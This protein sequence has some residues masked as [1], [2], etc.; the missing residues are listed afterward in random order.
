MPAFLVHGVPD[1]HHL[2]DGV[3]SRLSRE[4]VIAPDLPGFGA[5]LPA[6]FEPVK[7]SYVD[8]LIG[9]IEAVGE[10]VDLV[11]HDWGS[12]L[13]IRIASVRPDLVRTWACGAGA[14]DPGYT[15]HP[16]AQLW[17]TPGVGEQFMDAFT[18]E[19]AMSGLVGGGMPEDYAHTAV[20]YIDDTMK[21]CI[22]KLYR[23]AVDF[24]HEWDADLPNMPKGGLMIWGAGDP[25]MPVAIAEKMAARVGARVVSLPDTNHWWPAQR[26]AEVA[27]LLEEHWA[28]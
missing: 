2:W 21:D 12:L 6:G 23:S 28:L 3:R 10:P 4:D 7:E 25:Y 13:S 11:G 17:Q 18:P 8:W 27:A 20:R 9:Q 24:M 16:T 26:P 1:T 15:W 22:L 19:T 14:I 5:P